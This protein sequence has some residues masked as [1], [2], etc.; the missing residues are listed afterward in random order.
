MELVL[1]LQRQDAGLIPGLLLWI[2]GAVL[3]QL[4]HWTQLLLGSDP[5]AT[6]WPKKKKK[7]DTLQTTWS[8]FIAMIRKQAKQSHL[9][10]R[11]TRIILTIYFFKILIF[12]HCS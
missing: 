5:Y 9:W 11:V 2:K 6:G 7:R 8:K 1:S 12:F 10:F 4:Q 3:L